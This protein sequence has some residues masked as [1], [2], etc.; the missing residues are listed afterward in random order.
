MTRPVRMMSARTFFDM[1]PLLRSAFIA[2]DDVGAERRETDGDI[3]GS[4]FSRRAVLDP[5][6]LADHDR[7][8][9]IHVDGP[10]FRFH[11]KRSR[12][13]HRILIEL[14]RLARLNPSAR[15]FHPGDAQ[16][17]SFGID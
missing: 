9:R 8:T 3:F 5:L 4:F 2:M 15:T 11:P 16:L 10:A 7:L 6:S 17:I 1:E 14:R 13:H 12:Q